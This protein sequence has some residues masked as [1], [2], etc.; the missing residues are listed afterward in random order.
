MRFR[1]NGNNT[2]AMKHNLYFDNQIFDIL[3][4]AICLEIVP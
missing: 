3:I 1:Q 2:I 4:G